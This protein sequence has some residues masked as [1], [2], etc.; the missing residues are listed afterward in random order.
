MKIKNIYIIIISLF[1]CI[2]PF[3]PFRS[4]YYELK[5]ITFVGNA[6]DNTKII[7][8]KFDSSYKDLYP[9]NQDSLFIGH[10][11]FIPESRSCNIPDYFF[12]YTISDIFNLRS[13]SHSI[14]EA[15]LNLD[16]ESL[17]S[18]IYLANLKYKEIVNRILFNG[19][20]LP[21]EKDEFNDIISTTS[22]IKLLYD[23][24]TKQKVIEKTSDYFFDRDWNWK[25]NNKTRTA[26]QLLLGTASFWSFQEYVNNFTYSDD[27]SIIKWIK[28]RYSRYKFKNL[29][30]GYQF[31]SSTLN[32]K[33]EEYNKYVESNTI[34]NVSKLF[35]YYNGYYYELFHTG[36][37]DYYYKSLPCYF[38]LNAAIMRSFFMYS[39]EKVLLNTKWN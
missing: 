6:V 4:I 8:E 11:S 30:S 15:L 21:T 22:F 36:F 32:T 16:P 35:N 39:D 33:R 9:E 29:S 20:W 31:D 34:L 7:Q 2:I 26:A 25:S 27:I 38:K 18:K 17:R 37:Y 13:S 19:F 14:Y 3:I 5:N 23:I 12:T 1:L 28:Y 24:W 10:T